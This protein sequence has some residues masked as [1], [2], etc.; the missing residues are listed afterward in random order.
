MQPAEVRTTSTA[1]FFFFFFVNLVREPDPASG[2][3]RVVRL[4]AGNRLFRR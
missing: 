1:W 2:G 4:S 3:T